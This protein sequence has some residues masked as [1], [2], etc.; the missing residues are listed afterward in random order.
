MRGLPSTV[1]GVAALFS[2]L[3][4]ELKEIRYQFDRPFVVNS[5]AY[6]AA[7]AVRS[8]PVDEQVKETVAWWRERLA[9]GGGHG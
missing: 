4:R 7:F 5:S 1:V 6:E 9:A 3:I 2:P 8:T